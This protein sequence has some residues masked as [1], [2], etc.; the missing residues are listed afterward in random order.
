MAENSKTVED[1]LDGQLL[2]D[3]VGAVEH[4]IGVIEVPMMNLQKHPT[5]TIT[6]HE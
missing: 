4:H 5:K 3:V 1:P 6:I 2:G